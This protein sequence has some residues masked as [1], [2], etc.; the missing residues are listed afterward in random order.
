MRVRI[1]GELREVE[2]TT[3]EAVLTSL[4]LP[5]DRVAVEHNGA[6]VRRAERPLTRINDGDVLEIVTLVGGG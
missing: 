4:A 2:A 6:I 3:I 1:N 5:V